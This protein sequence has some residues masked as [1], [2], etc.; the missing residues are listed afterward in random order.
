MPYAPGAAGRFGAAQQTRV[1]MDGSVRIYIIEDNQAILEQLEGI[2][3]EYR[4][5]EAFDCEIRVVGDGFG[6]I[7]DCL[8][9]DPNGTNIYFLD[10]VLG[11]ANGLKLAQKIRSRDIWG[12]I[13]FVTSHLEFAFPAIQYKIRALDY[14]L[15]NDGDMRGRVFQCLDTIRNELAK[16]GPETEKQTILIKTNGT[17][18]I[19]PLDE[20]IYFETNTYKRSIIMH[21]QNKTIEFRDTLDELQKRL[22]SSF[23]R[24]HRSY[25]INL[26]YVATISRKRNDLHVM[27]KD[28]TKCLISPRYLRGLLRYEGINA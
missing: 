7:P 27:L 5:R 20:I 22:N 6:D 12:Y 24:C 9:I 28:G 14:I 19:I 18:F 23:Y 4:S 16:R 17:H 25:L 10:I 3:A 21:T 2:V 11:S 13:I 1:E 26:H 8:N 15:K